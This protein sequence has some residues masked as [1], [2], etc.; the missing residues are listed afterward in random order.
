[1][2]GGGGGWWRLFPKGEFLKKIY[3]GVLLLGWLSLLWIIPKRRVPQNLSERC[4]CLGTLFHNLLKFRFSPPLSPH[5]A[6]QS[7]LLT[8]W[9]GGW[10]GLFTIPFF[11]L[12]SLG[13]KKDFFFFFLMFLA[14]RGAIL[15]CISVPTSHK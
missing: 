1:M 9:F 15:I 4:Q 3:R 12:N 6:F 11:F 2:G 14:M 7:V 8:G 10:V 13:K 5:D